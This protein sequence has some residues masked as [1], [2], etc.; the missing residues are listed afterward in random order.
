MIVLEIVVVTFLIGSIWGGAKYY[1]HRYVVG[2][3][4]KS[5][6]A[7]IRFGILFIVLPLTGLIVEFFRWSL[8]PNF[9]TSFHVNIPAGWGWLVIFALWAFGYALLTLRRWAIYLL[10]AG[11][12]ILSLGILGFV[13][14][15]SSPDS[16]LWSA[17]L[18]LIVSGMLFL[19]AKAGWNYV[20]E[21]WHEYR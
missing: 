21:R 1:D 3:G 5:H 19:N 10:G 6:L 16:L 12:G 13:L 2:R 8:D 4:L 18:F 20:R 7:G 15:K 11:Y 17:A 9:L 14:L